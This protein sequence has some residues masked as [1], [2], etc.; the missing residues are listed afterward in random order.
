M[1]EVVEIDADS[2][3]SRPRRWAAWIRPVSGDVELT[4]HAIL[5]PG[6]DLTEQPPRKTIP[7]QEW[8]QTHADYGM[9]VNGQQL[10]AR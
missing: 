9:D 6:E 5:A 1:P 10:E 3:E 4:H 8:Q 2:G 7:L